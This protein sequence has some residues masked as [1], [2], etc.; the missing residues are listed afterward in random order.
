MPTHDLSQPLDA[1][2]SVYPGDPDVSVTP[3]ATHEADGYRVHALELGTHGGTHVDAPSHLLPDGRD[4]DEFDLSTFA[5]DAVRIDC[6]DY[7]AREPIGKDAV[8][9][10][11]SDVDAGTPTDA[12]AGTPTDAD[13][14]TPTD[15]DAV[16]VH[17]GWSAYWGTDQYF[18]HPYLS[19]DAAAA[20]AEA[21]LHVGVD[22]P[23]VDPTPSATGA[24]SD[25]EPEGFP[26]HRELLGSDRLLVEN[27]HNLGALPERFELCAYPLPIRDA[28]GAPVRAVARV[29]E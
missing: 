16:V 1:A 21:G 3:H 17:T 11:L 28:D 25:D 12:D 4:L 13:A 27:L 18:D 9:E 19:A 7:G 5:F 24:G 20:L 22:T 29:E 6:T 23:N 14:G 2:G 8:V 15:A 26:A 10:A